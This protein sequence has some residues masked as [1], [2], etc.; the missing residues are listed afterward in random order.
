MNPTFGKTTAIAALALLLAT[1]LGAHD[2]GFGVSSF[3]FETRVG[4]EAAFPGMDFN[5]DA[6]GFRGSYLNM[7]L[8]GQICEGLTYSYRQRFNKL[9][10][11]TFFD[12]TDWI[13]IDWKATDWFT[14]GGGKQVVGIGGYEYDRAPIDL[15]YC[16]EFWNNIACYQLGISGTFSVAPGD[17]LLLQVCNSPMR[18]YITDDSGN[19]VGNSKV[20]VNLMWYGSHGF[21]ESIWSANAFQNSTDS[22][23][24]YV[25][26]GNRFNITEWLRWDIDLMDRLGKGSGFIGDF[27]IMSEI[28]A[29]PVDGLRVHAKFTW[30]RNKECHEDWLVLSGTNVRTV[31][32]G[33]EYHPVKRSRDAVKLFAMAGYSFGDCYGFLGNKDL[34][35]Q[36]GVKFRLDIMEGVKDLIRK[37]K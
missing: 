25:A 33:V 17:N 34:Q 11:R 15:Y 5:A 8:D 1:G 37:N 26:L 28:S 16:S 24:Y 6:S 13:H 31:S 27:S 12:A 32:G 21:Y 10:D 20:A 19:N 29:A 9:S 30:D 3:Y 4:Y 7:R 14:L 22:W 36:A 18:G 35:I 23:M 2:K